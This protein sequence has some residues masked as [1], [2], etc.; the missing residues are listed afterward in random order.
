MTRTHHRLPDG[1]NWP[2]VASGMTAIENIGGPVS[3]DDAGPFT[4]SRE[5]LFAL[6]AIVGA[7]AHLATHPAGAASVIAQLRMLRR[8]EAG[9]V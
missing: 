2:T 4:V 8:A 7:Y 3:L 5:D 6:R 9:N 1:T